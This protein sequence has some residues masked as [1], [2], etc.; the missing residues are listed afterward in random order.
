MK[1]Q[2]HYPNFPKTP[3]LKC[4]LSGRQ[5]CRSFDS[6]PISFEYLSAILWAANGCNR[7]HKRTAPAA[8]GRY[9][10]CVYA[11]INHSDGYAKGLYLHKPNDNE[12]ELIN[13][14]TFARDIAVA[15]KRQMFLADAA[16]LL[17]IAPQAQKI[18]EKY[19]GQE[20]RFINIEAGH[21]AQN[22]CLM[23]S[24]LELG[25][26]CVGVFDAGKI[27]NILGLKE[28]PIYIVAIGHKSA[29]V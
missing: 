22:A 29:E 18:M 3:S 9:L 15:A 6:K 4:A 23:A 8:H 16:C 12:A 17:I 26:C 13:A 25:S 2:E 5:S 20:W 19:T 24:A 7:P 21:I 14:G 10:N 1:L 28:E 11:L 27:Q